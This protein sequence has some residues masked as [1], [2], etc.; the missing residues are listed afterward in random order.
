MLGWKD[1]GRQCLLG[2]RLEVWEVAQSSI[3]TKNGWEMMGMRVSLTSEAGAAVQT[4]DLVIS[5]L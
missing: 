2:R 4:T 5:V 3:N 1:L